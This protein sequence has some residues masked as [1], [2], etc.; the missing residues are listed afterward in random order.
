M[1]SP[2]GPKP[3]PC[4][5]PGQPNCPPQP[6]NLMINYAAQDRPDALVYTYN[7]MLAY[8]SACYSKGAADARTADLNDLN[9]TVEMVEK[10]R[11]EAKEHP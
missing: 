2:Y 9:A 4:G 7:D 6:A 1:G 5:S 8:G 10:D 11:A 3:F